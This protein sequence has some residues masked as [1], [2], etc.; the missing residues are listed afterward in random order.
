[1]AT[2]STNQRF[3]NIL[4]ETFVIPRDYS[5]FASYTVQLRQEDPEQVWIVKP[6]ASSRGRGIYLIK[7]FTDLTPNDSM[8]VQRY[9]KNP[10]LIDGYKFDMRIY[11]LVTSFQP[12][13]VFL[14]KEGFARFSSEK[15]T[16]DPDE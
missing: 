5:A 6:A 10:L 12:L 8:V 13:E 7:E 2:N 14:Y 11:V 1:M 4:P 16:L 9:I 3:F 15:F